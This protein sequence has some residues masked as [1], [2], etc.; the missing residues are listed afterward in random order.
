MRHQECVK[1]HLTV[2]F[3]MARMVNCMLR[4][5]YLKITQISPGDRTQIPCWGLNGPH[6]VP[7][8]APIGMTCSSLKAS[9]SPAPGPWHTLSL[10]PVMFLSLTFPQ[11]SSLFPLSPV[12][13]TDLV[14]MGHTSGRGPN[15]VRG[16][17][18]LKAV[19]RR[20]SLQLAQASVPVLAPAVQS[21]TGDS[22]S[23]CLSFLS[24]EMEIIP[25][26]SPV[27]VERADGV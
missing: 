7:S 14:P 16:V 5:F 10:P 19:A 27:V 22:T 6:R 23:L 21:W 26:L 11:L 9:V 15:R 1:S 25:V 13:D 20:L 24:C 12:N 2:Y 4:G 18:T 3:K 17:T 8:H